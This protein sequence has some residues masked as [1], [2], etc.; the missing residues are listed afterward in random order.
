MKIILTLLI[1][2]WAKCTLGYWEV[3]PEDFVEELC[4]EPL[5]FRDSK[6]IKISNQYQFSDIEIYKIFMA[7]EPPLGHV[8][9]YKIENR[10]YHFNGDSVFQKDDYENINKRGCSS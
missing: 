8:I 10:F 9:V 5:I 2:V 6:I 7:G 1:L 3:F 4:E